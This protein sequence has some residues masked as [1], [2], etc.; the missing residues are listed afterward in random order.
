[1]LKDC[2]DVIT[3]REMAKLFGISINYAYK[4]LDEGAIGYIKVGHKIL[5]P[6]ICIADFLESA[7][8]INQ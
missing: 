3:V 4:L 8:I 6:K 2:S 7:R 1:M 5:I